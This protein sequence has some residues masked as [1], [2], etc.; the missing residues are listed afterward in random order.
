MRKNDVKQRVGEKYFQNGTGWK[1]VQGG[2]SLPDS[3]VIRFKRK[4]EEYQR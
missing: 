4:S 2:E 1:K 3:T